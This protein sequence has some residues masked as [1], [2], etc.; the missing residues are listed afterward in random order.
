M[1]AQPCNYDEVGVGRA[2][3]RAA[4]E[5]IVRRE[6]TFIQTK[7]TPAQYRDPR[8]QPRPPPGGRDARERRGRHLRPGPRPQRRQLH[9]SAGR[10]GTMSE[11]HMRQDVADL[12]AVR[13]LAEREQGRRSLWGSTA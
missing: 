11:A 6:D 4:G 2:I 7:F 1:A 10:D 13:G 5:G 12:E 8:R 3:W 9:G